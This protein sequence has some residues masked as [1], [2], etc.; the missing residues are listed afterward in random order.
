[1]KFIE[2][3]LVIVSTCVLL[4]L[5]NIDVNISKLANKKEITKQRVDTSIVIRKAYRD[6]VLIKHSK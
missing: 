3:L 5:L 6:T 1:M 4:L 2:V